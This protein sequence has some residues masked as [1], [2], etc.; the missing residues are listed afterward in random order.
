MTIQFEHRLK[1]GAH[2]LKKL[3]AHAVFPRF[4]NKKNPADFSAGFL[5]ICVM[6]YTNLA[7]LIFTPGPMVAETTQDLTY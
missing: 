3:D 1:N 7:G 2:L 5:L 6:N 4:A